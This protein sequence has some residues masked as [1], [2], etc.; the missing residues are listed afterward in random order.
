[1]IIKLDL[2]NAFDRVRHNFLFKVMENFGFAPSFINCIKAC[3]GPPWIAP[4]VNGRATKFF[5]ASRGLRQGCP[6]SPLLYAIQASVLSFQLDHDQTHNN[7]PGL[8]IAPGV[9]DINHAQF[10][11]DTQLMGGA[12]MPTT[13]KFKKELDA[14]TQIS[15]SV[16][17]LT[18]SKIFG[19]NIT[20]REMLYISRVLGM[21]GCTTWD[22][23]KY[24]GVPIFKYKPKSSHWAQLIE[25]LKNRINFWGASCLN[26]AGKVVLI[27]AVLASIPIYQSSLLLASMTTIHKIE[28]M[29]RIFLWEGGKQTRRKLHLIR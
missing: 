21:E 26:L 7:L 17:S 18:K 6:L 14:Y 11:D 8:R 19:W 23:F 15:G 2:E 24:L 10:A 5:Q 13:K 29:F 16:I 12:S 9:K 22:A 4:L 3:I 28:M 25:K 27:K 20:P 1:M